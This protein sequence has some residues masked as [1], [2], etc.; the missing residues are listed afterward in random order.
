MN[1]LWLRVLE[2]VHGHLGWLSVVALLH[3]VIVLRRPRRRA[4]LATALATGIV[5]LAF[6][7]GTV[8]YP[9]YRLL[10]KQAIFRTNPRIGW[11]FERKEHLAV[12]VLAFAWVG[13]VAHWLSFGLGT[14]DDADLRARVERIAQRGYAVSFALGVAVGVIGVTV[15]VFKTF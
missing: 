15:A 7:L 8:V 2:R 13:L 5:T 14:N 1:E 10:L 12:G 9:S 3:P 11:L 4:R 6:V